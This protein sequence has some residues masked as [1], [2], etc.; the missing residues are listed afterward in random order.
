M[1]DHGA[2]HASIRETQQGKL[3]E[4]LPYFGLWFPPGFKSHYPAEVEQVWRNRKRMTT[5]FDIHETLSDLLDNRPSRATRSK[6]RGISLFKP[7]PETRTCEQ[8]KVEPHW[9]PCLKWDNITH[10]EKLK[11]STAQTVVEFLNHLTEVARNKCEILSLDRVVSLSVFT[12]RKDVLKYMKSIDRHGDI[13]DMSDTMSVIFEFF[14][15]DLFTNPGQGRFQ[16]TVKHSLSPDKLS[17]REQSISRINT[18]GNA[19]ACVLHTFPNLRRFCQC[20]TGD[21]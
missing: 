1:A 18:Y 12:P 14:Q 8:A 21:G 3:E 17:V 13:A 10:D 2:R 15:I 20:K 4:R 16:V 5:Q 9:C 7:I 19:P 6:G 11:A